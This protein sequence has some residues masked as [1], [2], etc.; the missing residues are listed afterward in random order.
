MKINIKTLSSSWHPA[1]SFSRP[2]VPNMRLN[3]LLGASLL[4]ATWCLSTNFAW[5]NVQVTDANAFGDPL[6]AHVSN[7]SCKK[8]PGDANYPSPSAWSAFND[9]L[10]GVLLHPSPLASPCYPGLTYNPSL[11]TF[12]EAN[13]AN[14][15]LH[16]SDPTSVVAYWPEG[17]TCL[18][19]DG[20]GNSTCT[21]AGLPEY[22]VNVS[23]VRDVQLAVNY[24]RNQN[25]RL[26]VK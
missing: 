7:I 17:N 4:P 1:F 11:C 23:T 21:N 10:D 18:P 19:P 14:T 5:E 22:V 3:N 9:T 8:H 15:S 24:A 13:F 25:L 26:V 6:K 2:P 12:I 16:A 20:S